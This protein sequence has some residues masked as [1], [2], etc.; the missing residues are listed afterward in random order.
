[1]KNKLFRGKKRILYI[2][3]FA[4]LVIGIVGLMMEMKLK[5]LMNIYMENQVTQEAKTLS[6]LSAKQ[7]EIEI[8]Y[9]ERVAANI[10]LDKNIDIKMLTNVMKED[11]DSS[12]GLICLDGTTIVGSPLDFTVYTGIQNSFR[13]NSSVSYNENEGLVFTVPVYDG[14][15]VQYVLYRMYD[16]KVLEEKFGIS[17][18]DNEGSV[19]IIDKNEQI[20]VPFINKTS[21][22][23]DLLNDGAV[24]NAM[25]K[26]AKQMNVDTAATRIYKQDDNEN[27]LFIS[28][29]RQFN[30]YLIGSVPKLIVA[31]GITTIFVLLLWVFGLLIVMFA[32]GMAYLLSAQEKV[33]E[34][35]AL[36]EA[37]NIAEQANRSKSDFL[38]NM[39]HEIR[40]PLN[41]IMGLNEMVV[42]ESDSKDIKEYAINIRNASQ[43]LLS[44]INDILDFS[45]I[46][47]G[48]IEI[49]YNDYNVATFLNDVVN[50]ARIKAEQKELEFIVEVDETIP[51]VLFGDEVRNRQVIVNILNNAIKYTKE[52]TVKL[53][54]SGQ[55]NENDFAMKLEVEDTGIGIKEE[56]IDKLFNV[57]QR[58][59]IEK[60]RNIEGT[61]LGLAIT[62]N[63]VEQMN[64][65]IEVYS[66][67]GKG[68]IFT[69]YLNQRIIDENAI[70]DFTTNNFDEE[71]INGSYKKFIAPKASILVV[72]DNKMN[73]MVVKE[74][75]KETQISIIS[76]M[77]GEKC[78]EIVK[79]KHFDL[80]LLDHMMPGMDGMETL[81]R[82]NEEEHMCKNVPVIVL[83]ANAI[84]GAKEEYLEAGFADYLSKPIDVTLLENI[85]IRYID[86]SK[87][88]STKND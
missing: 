21:N 79:K 29:I 69:I 74:L 63:L 14:Q 55:K 85:L 84:V 13:G 34:S 27:F 57:F 45:K 43:T 16:E 76:C 11:T 65:K 31:D 5:S 68:S 77:S 25:E 3:I 36:R 88:I 46:E 32:V 60:N 19:A 50:M 52:G 87:I 2:L 66:E 49:V 18:Y 7:F 44:L 82:F 71:E 81:K 53:K 30:L 23:D 41:A 58:L 51:S 40:T 33:Q 73:L 70:G 83:T 61:G 37:K 12:Y 8:V 1:M 86:E 17:C 72:D 9:L 35:E 54:V 80:I 22:V 28:E 42:R 26:I 75:L 62:H 39:S 24:R 59:E 64:G 48:K 47:A 56:D 4:T 15:N 20:V 6:E 38:A 78:L 10:E 67:Y